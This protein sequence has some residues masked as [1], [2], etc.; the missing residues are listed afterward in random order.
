MKH[1]QRKELAC[2]LVQA[3]GAGVVL[4]MAVTAAHAQAQKVEKIEVT[5]SNI[6]RIDTE[7]A[8]PVQIITREEI[9][10][11]GKTTITELLRSLP[12]NLTGGLNDLTGSNSF[13]SGAS[14]IS[15]RGLGS[16][17]TLV[18]LNGRRIAPFGLADPNFGQSAVVNLDSL[19]L[20]VVDR[21]EILK[22]G[23]SAIYGS[24]AVA[25][26]VNIILRKDYKGAQVAGS[27]GMNRGSE[28]KRW[29]ASGTI[30][31]GDLA[32]DRYNV[33]VNAEHY[34]RDRVQITDVEGY[35][36]NPLLRNSGYATGRHFSSSYAGSYLN[37]VFDPVTLGT[38]IATGFRPAAQQ[39]QC[40]PG[41]VRDA[42]GIC[43]W[44][45][46]PRQQIEP[47]SERDSFY[48][49]GTIEFANGLAAFGELGYNR[50]K[51]TYTGNPQV[52]GDFGVWYDASRQRLVGLP[53]VLPVGHPNNPYPTPVLYRHRFVEVGNTDRLTETEATRGLAGVRGSFRNWDWESAI[54]YSENKV[55]VTNFN[56]IR[57]SVLRAGVLNGTYNFF[58]PTA[59]AITPDMLRVNTVDNA[60]SSFTIWDL[61]TSGELMQMASG[62]LAMAAGVEY[63][64][65]E[66]K[67]NPDPLKTTG[68]IVGFGASFA[69]GS[70]NVTSLYG[71]LSVPVLRNLEVQLAAR[72]DRYSDYGNSTTPKIGAKWKVLP[73]LALRANYAE[74]FRAPS[75]T[76]N[77]KSS[78]S[79]FTVV[80]DPKR[81][82]N[83]DELDCARTVA[84]LIEANPDVQPE[85]AKTYTAGLVWE[86]FA[87]FSAALDM[88]DI[89]RKHEISILDTD[90]ILA[91][92]D[93][94]SPFYAGRVI[95]GTPAGDGLPGQLQAIKGPFSNN[96]E[97]Q[98]KGLD[99]DFLYIANVGEYGRLRN[100]VTAT[101]YHSWKGNGVDGD[102]LIEFVGYR[103]PRTRAVASVEWQYRAWIVGLAGNY[104]RGYHV[105][106]DPR[107]PCRTASL[108]GP[109]GICEVPAR[110]WANVAVEYSGIKNL[111]IDLIVE[112]IF[113]K[114][115]PLD[116][117]SRPFNYTYHSPL[118]RS[119][120][121][122]LGATYKFR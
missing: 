50:I 17:A 57:A 68:E 42:G 96:G 82:I 117:L 51:T 66:R 90:T 116:P 32:R 14:T 100:R 108:L 12:S 113:D 11:S 34:D 63:R 95:R 18:L 106:S 4:S 115:Q 93:N 101:Y 104:I 84:F 53:E 21:I 110:A 97:T 74:A 37:A 112:N 65:E 46:V 61:K 9:E 35:V 45:L 39:P 27:Y 64:R 55:E 24:E 6:K 79:A 77:S 26:V 3:L 47:E 122:T 67:A 89:R 62:P 36:I 5:G 40:V 38:A 107:I 76:E 72:T 58:N 119:V 49:R 28:Y 23:A 98:V 54:L 31:I 22:D 86:P 121:A 69:E 43:R 94:P 99:L 41:A 105:S 52:Y 70:R 29:R 114:Q 91:N 85:E 81:C 71:E 111:K 109:S 83:G 33:F 15:L 80:T 92:E 73:S 48:S 59:G 13:S 75:L 19:P 25:G 1:I 8:A 103:V 44:D 88:F 78:V 2:A 120:F 7:T 20:D 118:Y 56:H 87:N 16:T 30:G 10:R 60:K 102:P